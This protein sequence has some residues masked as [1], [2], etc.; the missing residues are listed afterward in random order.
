MIRL[1]LCLF[2]CFAL[3]QGCGGEVT[4]LPPD[5]QN[6]PGRCLQFDNGRGKC[7]PCLRDDQC[8]SEAGSTKKCT[9]ENRCVCGSNK[10]CSVGKHCN[11]VGG[12]VECLSDKNCQEQ[13]P[14][15]PYCIGFICFECK[16]GE[17]RACA[18]DGLKVCT[19]GTQTCKASKTWG[20]CEGWDVCKAG[21]I[22]KESICI[23][24]C[25]GTDACK[26]ADQ[27]CIT[28]PKDIPGRYQTCQQD[29]K[30]CFVY[31]PEQ[32]CD[33]KDV[34]VRGK[35]E[36][37]PCTTPSCVEGNTQCVELSSFKTCVMDKFGCLVWSEKQACGSGTQCFN[38]ARKCTVCKPKSKE[39]CYSGD[40]NTK[41][42]GICKSGQKLCA[43]DGSGFGACQG[44][45]LSQ[46][47]VCNGKD[48]D[49]NGSIDD[50]LISPFCTLQKGL[51]IGSKQSCKGEKG[52]KDCDLAA[53][54][55]WNS[56]FISDEGKSHC[57]GKDNDC[58]GNIDEGCSCKNGDTQACYNGRVGTSGMGICKQGQQTCSLGS[59]G[60]CKGEVLPTNEICNGKDDNCDGTVDENLEKVCYNGQ[61]SNSLGR[62]I[63]KAGKQKCSNGKWGSCVGEVLPGKESC[64]NE[65]DDCDGRIDENLTQ[66]CFSGTQ[67]TRAKGECKD[68][69]QTCTS[70]AWGSCIGE[71]LP[72]SEVCNGKDD[73]C[74]GVVDEG[75]PS[76][77]AGCSDTTKKGLCI[78]GKLSCQNGSLVCVSQVNP[79]TEICGN[80]K[81]D[82]CDG[83]VDEEPCQNP[84]TGG[85]YPCGGV[86]VDRKSNPLHCGSCQHVC[87]SS[88]ACVNGSCF[89]ARQLS[90]P[91]AEVLGLAVDSQGFVYISGS[92]SGT[93]IHGNSTLLSKGGKDLFVAKFD[94]KGNPLKAI[95]A[96]G[97]S[98]DASNGLALLGNHV[99]IVGTFHSSS[100]Q[101]TN[102]GTY[103]FSGSKGYD[104]FVAKLD[105]NLSWVKVVR[106]GST[107]DEFG[108][109][110]ATDGSH[111]YITGNI[112]PGSPPVASKFGGYTL[113]Q[114]GS[115]YDMFVAKLDD[116]LNW[117]SAARGGGAAHA[118]GNGIAASSSHV[119]VAGSFNCGS[120]AS[121]FGSF[122]T[123]R[124]KG[125]RNND[126]Y[127]ARLDKKLKFLNAT[128]AGTT[129]TKS[130]WAN[131]LV[132]DPNGNVFVTGVFDG[133]GTRGSFGSYLATGFG[134]KDVYVAKLDSSLKW[135]GVV[136][137]G[138][139]SFREDSFGLFATQQHVYVTGSM[140]GTT[141]F[142]GASG[143]LTLSS[144]GSYDVFVG[145]V[146]IPSMKFVSAT[147]AGG[148][149]E[150][151]GKV[152]FVDSNANIYLGGFFSGVGSFH[153]KQLTSSGASP[154]VVKNLP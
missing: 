29:S 141:F 9:K 45:V 108:N 94:N 77:G 71:I 140:F 70:G 65:D 109:E 22:C 86:C 134:K 117:L 60:P 78:Q 28:G 92:F 132:V 122:G 51:C 136:N 83:K 11:G 124:L 91:R 39:S 142:R 123:V 55:A 133:G 21:Q 105:N 149:G 89:W 53:Y 15:R 49:C 76:G 115:N 135:L 75:N 107:A 127:V 74:N 32:T 3:L 41:G 131:A 146:D 118:V 61:P 96:G 42:L 17:S 138:G 13:T 43:V 88:N 72:Q 33:D 10:D 126:I 20:P 52:W 87:G 93:L 73:N 26:P 64:N 46:S 128:A 100:N 147:S 66:V 36:P 103:V 2:L 24:D 104:V 102:F 25:S 35:C 6:C 37:Y 27:R 80:S 57:D 82:S 110:I 50:G 145:K 121:T 14:E 19:Q 106:G 84:C 59:W 48:D 148:S 98:N 152:V 150:D 23:V 143:N 114:T 85:K 44:E 18:P 12:C 101:T 1:S 113:P 8:R 119:Y 144:K 31:G 62:G 151:R 67:D 111:L 69:R 99:Y 79:V 4:L 116:N 130:D 68:G 34:C 16:T 139:A 30:G 63:C 7:V 38:E 5:C 125:I 154:F 112:S 129:Q 90:G 137:A 58:D 81:D 95:S 40:P 47:E 54:Q 153:T 120:T 56:L 97:L